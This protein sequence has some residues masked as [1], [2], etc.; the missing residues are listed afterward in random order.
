MSNVDI[1]HL[2]LTDLVEKFRQ[3]FEANKRIQTFQEYLAMA[4]EDPQAACRDAATY[5]RDAFEY[6]G[7]YD[8]E[9][10]W[11]RDRRWRLFDVEF[12]D[13]RDQLIGQEETQSEL[14]RLLSG[15]AHEGQVDRLIVLNGPNGSAKST[16]VNALMRALETY[17][18]TTEGALYTVGWVFPS[19]MAMNR[20]GFEG[21]SR[22]IDENESYAHLRD[23]D[24]DARLRCEVR[25]HPLLALPLPDRL[26]LLRE[27]NGGELPKLPEIFERGGLCHKCK[28]VFDALVLAYHG[29]LAKVLQHMRVE[30]W[31]ISRAY[32]RG[33]ITIGP[34]MS[35]DAGERQISADRSLAALP[36]S[37]QMSTLFETHGE[38]VD[39]SGGLL[40]FS[41]L[42]KR[43]LDAFRYLLGTIESGEVNL[44]Q[45]ILKL[46]TVMVATTNDRHLNAFR[47]HPEYL[48]FRGRLSVV[49]VPYIRNFRTEQQIY[50]I[51]LVP[52]IHRHVAPHAT[53]AA[54]RWAVYTR[55]LSPNLE[56]YDKPHREMIKS[57]SAAEK[58]ELFTTGKV[59]EEIKG[60]QAEE[61]RGLIG[62]IYH[63]TDDELEYEG[64]RGA[65]PREIRTVL[66]AAAQDDGFSCLTPQAVLKHIRILCNRKE[67]HAFLQ[68]SSKPGGY[69][70]AEE[71]VDDVHE[72]MLD[73]VEDELRSATGL[74]AEERH[75]ELLER[76]VLNVRHW[77]K[78]EKLYNKVTGKDEEPD[79]SLMNQ[80]DERLDVPPATTED[81]RKAI[82]STIA[83]YALEHPGEPLDIPRIFP[84]HLATL[85]ASYFSEH[86]Q[87][88]ARV[89]QNILT[90]LTG[91]RIAD[92]DELEEA[93]TALAVLKDRFGYC[94]DCAHEALNDLIRSRYSD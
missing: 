21:G 90:L 62:D 43:P 32:R 34:Q 80:V 23:E 40:E 64:R 39:S 70:G 22:G 89:G 49:R 65:S 67:E 86:Q 87:K 82:I 20:I 24:V 71:L 68:R 16:L 59:P 66:T 8:V 2:G 77:V 92:E 54:A 28:Q 10:P 60:Q 29:D 4:S 52:N 74:V 58:A 42:L 13:G 11:G 17:S 48:S 19:R 63:E 57:L 7:S 91:D 6:F 84:D 31:Y 38:L 46:N 35:V 41:D 53:E 85:R 37:L 94:D 47:E 73:A 81:F 78:G 88:V 56:A 9:R 14:Y 79:E 69:E 72:A 51:R 93:R 3:Q 1:K 33:A 45:S 75:V 30:R 36:S 44:N 18:Q 12:D 26:D 55:L 76:Y 83:G 5:V 50:D 27:A 25:D 61:L 15:F